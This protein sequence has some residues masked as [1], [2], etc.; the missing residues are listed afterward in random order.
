MN[1][2]YLL[3][4]RPLPQSPKTRKPWIRQLFIITLIYKLLNTIA[5]SICRSQKLNK[6]TWK[7]FLFKWLVIYV[8]LHILHRHQKE[9]TTRSCRLFYRE[10]RNSPG[11]T[12]FNFLQC[13]GLIDVLSANKRA[14]TFACILLNR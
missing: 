14:E 1:K 10:T 13:L 4:N 3:K 8:Y 5:F 12:F 2:I 7:G 6:K 9:S 11:A